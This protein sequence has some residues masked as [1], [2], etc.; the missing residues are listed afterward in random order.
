MGRWLRPKY[1]NS[2]SRH[3]SV[4]CVYAINKADKALAKEKYGL[5]DAQLF[6]A[7]KLYHRSPRSWLS[8]AKVIKENYENQ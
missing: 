1:L 2:S 3:D 8:C 4:T 7:E 6:E 5:T